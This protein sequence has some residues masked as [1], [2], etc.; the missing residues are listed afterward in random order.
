MSTYQRRRKKRSRWMQLKD[1]GLLADYMKA[2]DF[3]QARLARYAECSRQFIWSLLNEERNTC[4]LEVGQRIE[5][6]LRVL[7][8]TLF[9][10]S[11]SPSGRPVVV[12]RTTTRKVP[13]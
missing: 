11:A 5:E 1:A 13:A 10:D 12:E 9:A 6:A 7:P 8:G 2:Q 4:T 3:S